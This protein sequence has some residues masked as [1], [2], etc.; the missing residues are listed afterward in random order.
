[1]YYNYV[2]WNPNFNSIKNWLYLEELLV[3]VEVYTRKEIFLNQ[4]ACQLGIKY[5]R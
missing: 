2:C 3:K 5:P 4:K 1:M